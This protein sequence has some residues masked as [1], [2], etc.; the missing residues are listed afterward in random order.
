MTIGEAIRK[1]R[2]N[3]GVTQTELAKLS[4]I[5][6]CSI[7]LYE[8]DIISPSMFRA[9]CIADVLDVTLDELVGRTVNNGST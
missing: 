1:A 4:G 5:E 2:K 7:C 8:R 6:Q 3:K 9:I